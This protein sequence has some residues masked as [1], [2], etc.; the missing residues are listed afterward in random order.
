[1]DVS[2][3]SPVTLFANI[4][5]ASNISYNIGDLA[6]FGQLEAAPDANTPEGMQRIMRGSERGRGLNLYRQWLERAG[7]VNHP[8]T[9]ADVV[10]AMLHF[11]DNQTET[12]PAQVITMDIPMNDAERHAL[13][14]LVYEMTPGAYLRTVRRNDDEPYEGNTV[15]HSVPPVLGAQTGDGDGDAPPP[16]PPPPPSGTA[17]GYPGSGSGLRYVYTVEIV[18]YYVSRL[19]TPSHDG[20]LFLNFDAARAASTTPQG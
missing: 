18:F 6:T 16:P 11:L 19:Q 2:R 12:L 20:F 17:T 14:M 3:V 4:R 5:E 13:S 9:F 15:A 10:G 7:D 8:T 1:M